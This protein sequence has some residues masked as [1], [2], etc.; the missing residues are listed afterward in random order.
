MPIYEFY[1]AACN[2]IFNFYSR[3]V[4]TTTRPLCPRCNK[5][6]L[7]RQISLFAAVGRAKED[8][9]AAGDLPLD[10]AK[11]ERAMESLAGEAENLNEDDPRQ[12]AAMMRKFSKLTG[13]EMGSS[14]QEAIG[15]IEAGENP[16]QVEAEMGD[17]MEQE[18]PFQMPEPK[19]KSK[20]KIRPPPRRDQTLYDL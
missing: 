17:R 5:R 6:K 15:R 11:M 19:A 16:E 2:T 8:T 20:G 3:T 18:E 1:C 14:M 7:E 13:M 12:A 10:D 9:G 4:N